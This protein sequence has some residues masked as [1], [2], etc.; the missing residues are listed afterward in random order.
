[1]AKRLYVVLA[2]SDSINEEELKKVGDVVSLGV[3][4]DL[5]DSKVQ[6]VIAEVRNSSMGADIH[7]YAMHG[8]IV[9][10]NTGPS[11]NDVM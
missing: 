3:K 8:K 1:M 5:L 7:I 6:K 4:N 11:L 2:D 9:E 10:I